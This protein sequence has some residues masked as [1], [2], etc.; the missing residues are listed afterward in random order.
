VGRSF[1]GDHLS[2]VQRL[3]AARAALP[4]QLLLIEGLPRHAQHCVVYEGGPLVSW[5]VI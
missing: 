3:A 4:L 2:Q 5:C 1:L